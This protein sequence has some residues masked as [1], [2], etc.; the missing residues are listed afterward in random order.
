MSFLVSCLNA[1]G[2]DLCKYEKNKLNQCRTKL[3]TI[4]SNCD[5]SLGNQTAKISECR[6]SLAFAEG[7]NKG[8]EI[9]MGIGAVV[10]S[11]NRE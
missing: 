7:L 11:S 8:L 6:E 5:E 3:A 9:G 1:F 4:Q 2:I 10:V